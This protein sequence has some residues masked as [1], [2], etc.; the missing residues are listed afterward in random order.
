MARAIVFA[1]MLLILLP[2]IAG[3]ADRLVAGTVVRVDPAG[4]IY[5]DTRQMVNATM[6]TVVFAPTR[7]VPLAELPRGTFVIVRVPGVSIIGTVAAVDPLTRTIVFA[8]GQ[9][10]KIGS[11]V[12]VLAPT[13]PVPLRKLAP[14]TFIVTGVDQPGLV[15][16]AIASPFVVPPADQGFASIVKPSHVT[17]LRE[18]EYRRRAL[19]EGRG[20]TAAA[21][22][23]LQ[24]QPST[25]PTTVIVV[26]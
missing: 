5:L 15:E 12:P 10:L 8:D 25:V 21:G 3:S 19:R 13:L 24:Q 7:P 11:D 26:P 22:V 18:P 16:R 23:R 9:S 17:T 6:D 20:D 4:V 1:V 14:G 2:S